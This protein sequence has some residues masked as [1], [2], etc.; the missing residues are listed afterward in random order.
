MTYYEWLIFLV[1]DE[2]H[3][4]AT[5]TRIFKFLADTRFE[6]THPYD[7]NRAEDGL[8]LRSTYE[9]TV[10]YRDQYFGDVPPWAT[11]LE[12]LVALAIRCE[13]EIMYDPDEGDRTSL[14]FWTMLHNAGLD[15]PDRL[16]SEEKAERIVTRIM[17]NAYADDGSGG[18]FPCHFYS[19]KVSQKVS[20]MDI[21]Q[22]MNVFVNENFPV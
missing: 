11:F 20:Q 10:D 16:F 18:L 2:G 15:M 19:T 5:Y 14:W 3:D 13:S 17:K 6:W 22:Q 1:T 7:A 8:Y 12:V 21:W 4:Y 9:N